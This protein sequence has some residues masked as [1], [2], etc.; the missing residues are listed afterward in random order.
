VKR[1][2]YDGSRRWDSSATHLEEYKRGFYRLRGS[3]ATRYGY[4]AV[5]GLSSARIAERDDPTNIPLSKWGPVTRLYLVLNGRE[6]SRDYPRLLTRLGAVR[7]ARRF[8]EEV[9][10]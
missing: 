1:R 6:Y 9:Q 3:V 10:A 5:F 2:C 4:V 8:A 7:A